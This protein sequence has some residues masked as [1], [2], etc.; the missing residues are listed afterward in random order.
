MAKPDAMERNGISGAALHCADVEMEPVSPRLEPQHL[1]QGEKESGWI[2]DPA[3]EHEQDEDKDEGALA[4]AV[5]RADDGWL[6]RVGYS[7]Q[8]GK[9]LIHNIINARDSRADCH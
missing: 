1:A 9:T 4:R 5:A 3:R 8:G 2:S 6:L 7:M